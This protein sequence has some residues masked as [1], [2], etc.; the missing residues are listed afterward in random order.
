MLLAVHLGLTRPLLVH[1]GR[2]P[3]PL[4]SGTVLCDFD[5]VICD[6]E[7]E[8]V[9]S[10][11]RTACALWP[12]EMALADDFADEPWTAGARRAWAGGD[13]TALQGSTADGMPNWLAAKMRLLR[14]IHNSG[15]ESLL[16]L[17]LCAEE[18]IASSRSSERPLTPGE[19]MTNWSE[20][21]VELLEARYGLRREKALE[22][23]AETRAAWLSEDP[24]DFYAAS[25]C[26]PGAVAALREALEAD[27]TTS[28]HVVTC[29]QAGEV[30]ALLCGEG[31]S[32]A[33]D[34]IISLSSDGDIDGTAGTRT[35]AIRRSYAQRKADALF[36]LTQQAVGCVSYVDDSIDCLRS[37]ANDPRLFPCRLYYATWGYS[38]PEQQALA[39]SIPRVRSLGESAELQRVLR[40]PSEEEGSSSH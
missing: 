37:V 1:Q 10:A 38:N 33:G 9:R 24:A 11:W 16:L 25:K 40:P 20:E 8:L 21:M 3:R 7:P 23:H 4:A 39:A 35:A 12:K 27:D 32:L 17:R 13:W 15:H 36:A 26:Y 29:K 30:Q 22:A 31:L 2:A 28:V 14:P 5:G 18:A 19:I 34:R 6:S